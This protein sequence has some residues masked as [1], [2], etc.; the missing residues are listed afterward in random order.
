MM[1]K[2]IVLILLISCGVYG[3]GKR[4]ERCSHPCRYD[5]TVLTR[6]SDRFKAKA[7][8]VEH[9]ADS[10]YGTYIQYA[11]SLDECVEGG[12]QTTRNTYER[13]RSVMIKMTAAA[14]AVRLQYM[15][16]LRQSLC[17]K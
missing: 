11:N 5:P 8:E 4:R 13:E 2:F 12:L 10:I 7:I 6:T 17:F 14:G 3:S 16:A 15:Q 9:E 1:E